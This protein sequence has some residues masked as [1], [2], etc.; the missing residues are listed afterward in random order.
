VYLVGPVFASLNSRRE[1]LC[2]N[3]SELA[4]LWLSHHPPSGRTILLKGSRGIKL[5]TVIDAL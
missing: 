1:Y 3:D 2:F 4:L 5:E